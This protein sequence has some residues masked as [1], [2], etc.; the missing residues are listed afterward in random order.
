MGRWRLRR[1][2]VSAL[3]VSSFAC[4]SPAL[5][6]TIQLQ[7]DPVPEALGYRVFYGP[8][9]GNYT[10]S[11]AAGPHP[12][13]VLYDLP[14]CT[15]WYVAVKA[16]NWA[17]LSAQYSNEVAGWPRPTIVSIT[18]S[19]ADQGASFVLN[20]QGT[21]FQP[22]A[23]L[24]LGGSAMPTD[25]AGE[26]LVRVESSGT[27]S[28]DEL[29]ALIRVEP[30]AP[31]VRAM[32]V[33]TFAFDYEVRNPDR[34]YGA[35]PL[36]FE[37]LFEFSRWDINR[38]DAATRDRIDGADLSWLAYA[39]GSREGEPYYEPDA[40]LNGDGIV[41]GA[42][43]AYLAYGFGRCWSGTEWTEEACG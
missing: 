33:G 27:V 34:V 7:W 37:V 24:L 28:C 17:G 18:P 11:V 14:D 12:R 13:T 2:L 8:G 32:E 10:R 38:S 21:N 1:F 40:D 35:A 39:Y 43:L 4:L 22:G 6:G 30:S 9:P 20:V 19:S 23:R 41:D 36:D 16:Y 42:D 26:S 5:T 25:I 29:Q 31:G 15:T 3:L